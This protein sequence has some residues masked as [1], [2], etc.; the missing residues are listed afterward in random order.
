[1]A[2]DMLAAHLQRLF[3]ELEATNAARRALICTP[4]GWEAERRRLHAAYSSMLGA[5]PPRTPLHPRLTGTLERDRYRIEKLVYETRPGMLVTANAYVPKGRAEPVPGVL[6]PCGHSENGKAAE[7]YQR[8]CA[9]LA[10]KGYFVLIYDPVGQGERKLYWDAAR[11]E[12][13]LGGCTTQHSYA[14]NQCILFGTSLAQYMVWDSIRGMDYLCSR[15][16]VDAGRIAM[17]GNSGGG[18]NTAYTAPLDERVRV[19]IPCCYI[20]ALAWRRRSWTTGDAEQNL[21][22]QMPAGLDHA[23]LLRLV[24]PRPLLVGSAALDYFPL[25]GAR[26]S[27]AAARELYRTLGVS[28]RV[29]HAV[30]DAPHGYSLDLRRATYRWLNRWF[31]QEAEGDDEPDTPVEREADLRCTPAGQVEPLGSETIFS[32]NR[33]RLALPIPPRTLPVADAVVQLT[34]YESCA[35]RPAAAPPE[36]ALFRH[37]GLRRVERVVLWPESDVAVPGA[38]FTW[39]AFPGRHRAALWVDGAGTD[40]VLDRPAF[41]AAL[42]ELTPAGWL[43]LA[44]DVRGVGETAPRPTGRPNALL[45]GAEAFQTYE[46]FVAGRP[47]IGMRLRDVGCA[48][49]YLLGRPDVGGAAGVALVGWGAGGLLALHLAALDPRVAAVAT[50]DTLERYRSLV[51]PEHYAH[52]VSSF[53]PGVVANVDSPNGYDLDDL[54]RLVAPRPLLRLR[55]VDHLNRPLTTESDDEV[56]RRLVAWFEHLIP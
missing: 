47:L 55:S 5:F 6:V 29:A 8:V 44:I 7:T 43:H 31:D 12:S 16:E 40:A 54:A 28:E 35:A 48:V 2:R 1:M 49:D 37:E 9:G 11:H 53:V 14:G 10:A 46:S 26:E 50:V 52:P 22:G 51:E 15:A 33:R 27:V 21:L 32:L 17:A 20:T 38:A 39:R 24:A 45:M 56:A 34:G 36:T 18:T 25:E 30:A 42:A 13:R 3:V 4:D 41:R 23:D 19:A